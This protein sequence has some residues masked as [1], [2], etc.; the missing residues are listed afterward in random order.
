MAADRG[1]ETGQEKD[2]KAF[3]AWWE[4]EQSDEEFELER[5]GINSIKD[6]IERLAQVSWRAALEWVIGEHGPLDERVHNCDYARGRIK[7]ELEN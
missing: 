2:M 3:E 4:A 6:Y 1:R 7:N 5:G